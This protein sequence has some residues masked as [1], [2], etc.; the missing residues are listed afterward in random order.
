MR[1]AAALIMALVF[2]AVP[3]FA[4][5]LPCDPAAG[6][7]AAV[8]QSPSGKRLAACFDLQ[9][10][11]V[12]IRLPDSQVI[13]LPVAVSGSGARYSDGIRTFWEHQGVGR[14]FEGDAA[15]FEGT[16]VTGPRD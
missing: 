16:P 7:A 4:A 8:Y 1:R 3:L 6:Q 14:Y 5:E 2:G 11:R 12:T 15:L 13:T 10:H 9:Q